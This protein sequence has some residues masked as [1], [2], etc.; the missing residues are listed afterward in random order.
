[1]AQARLAE[2]VAPF[3]MVQILYSP[4]QRRMAAVVGAINLPRN[5]MAAMAVLAVVAM[6]LA[7]VV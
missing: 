3:Q 4:Q 5:I 2:R 6:V 7:L 1:L